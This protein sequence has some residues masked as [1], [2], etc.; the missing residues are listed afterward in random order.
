MMGS[1]TQVIFDRLEEVNARPRHPFALDGV[2]LAGRHFPVGGKAAKMVQPDDVNQ[3]ENG[4]QALQP[5]GVAILGMHLPAIEGVAPQLP[6]FRKIIRRNPRHHGRVAFLVDVE[7]VGTRP[8]LG[9]VMGDE[10][11][12]ISDNRDA[13][14][15]GGSAQRPPL[16]EEQELAEHLALDLHAVFTPRVLQ[17]FCLPVA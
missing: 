1:Y 7:Q 13:F 8:D 11:R 4:A 2:L 5:P 10:D 17:G 12:D 14:F 15:V 6:G 3:V 16:A 9:A